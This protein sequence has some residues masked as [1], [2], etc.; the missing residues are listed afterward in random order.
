MK[1]ESIKTKNL[2]LTKK[3]KILLTV[4]VILFLI[5][6]LEMVFILY[7]RKNKNTQERRSKKIVAEL[8][9]EEELVIR[10]ETM[11]EDVEKPSTEPSESTSSTKPSEPKE[12]EKPS[13][14]TTPSVIPPI[15]PIIIP[16][17]P[18]PRERVEMR[19]TDPTGP[20]L[21]GKETGTV[22]GLRYLT[23]TVA[24]GTLKAGDILKQTGICDAVPNAS[25]KVTGIMKNWTFIESAT[26]GESVEVVFNNDYFY[27][28][29]YLGSDLSMTKKAKMKVYVFTKEEG[30]TKEKSI[31][32]ETKYTFLFVTKESLDREYVRASGNAVTSKSVKVGE[33]ADIEIENYIMYGGFGF[34]EPGGRIQIRE[35]STN[36]LIGI[37]VLTGYPPCPHK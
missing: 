3:Q 11:V 13:E 31:V 37:G 19:W 27:R 17:L 15:K 28:K 16:K 23:V 18:G 30:N 1:E 7:A 25:A 10:E 2:S 9:E 8:Q 22:S 20:I 4:S 34:Y 32:N 14:E 33:G 29:S 36:D 21:Y 26:Q 24:R 12:P 35:T 6:C 5:L